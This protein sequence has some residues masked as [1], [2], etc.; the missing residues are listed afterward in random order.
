MSGSV[1]VFKVVKLKSK[2]NSLSIKSAVKL[3]FDLQICINIKYIV[4]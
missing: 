2:A 1:E 3:R 4:L